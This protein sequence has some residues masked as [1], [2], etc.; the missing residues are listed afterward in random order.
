MSLPNHLKSE[1]TEVQVL[2][3]TIQIV[4]ILYNNK[5]INIIM[6]LASSID[7]SYPKGVFLVVQASHVLQIV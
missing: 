2:Q 4:F 1:H 7:D 3:I 5:L 6:L